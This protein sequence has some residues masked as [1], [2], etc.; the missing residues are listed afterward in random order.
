MDIVW[1]TGPDA[2]RATW[3]LVQPMRGDDKWYNATDFGVNASS[4][5]NH[6]LDTRIGSTPCLPPS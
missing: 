6:Y 1:D 2:I 4:R 3:E 5:R